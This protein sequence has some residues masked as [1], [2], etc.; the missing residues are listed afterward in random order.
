[1]FYKLRVMINGQK[2]FT[3]IEMIAV[4]AITGLI[5]GGITAAI[6]NVW[7]VNALSSSHMTAVKQVENG[8]HW[9]S[10][11][12]QMAQVVDR[13][14]IAGFPLTLTWVEWDGTEKTVTYTLDGD[15]LIRSYSVDNGEEIQTSQIVV[16][17]QIDTNP[18]L[19]KCLWMSGRLTIKLTASVS[20]FREAIETREC[21]IIPRPVP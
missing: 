20:G 17:E 2:G 18:N 11:D 15:K 4:I 16:A 7:N 8:I 21:D 5:S 13:T 6:Y 3:L 14:G 9:M 10:R 12:A 1:M 19:T